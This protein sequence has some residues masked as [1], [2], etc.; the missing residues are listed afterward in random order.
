MEKFSDITVQPGDFVTLRCTSLAAPLAQIYWSIDGQTLPNSARYRFGDFVVGDRNDKQSSTA[1]LVSH[2]N[3]TSVRVEDGGLYRCTA[4][5][6]AGTV[7]HQARLNVYGKVSTKPH[8]SNIT[9]LSNSDVE[10]NCPFYGFPVKT[11]TWFGRGN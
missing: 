9:V 11:I 7:Y 3:I 1:R 2:F 4:K 5:N 10:L 6:I 8:L